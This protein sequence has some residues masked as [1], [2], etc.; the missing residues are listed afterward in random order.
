SVVI[1]VA[2]ILA[3]TVL[4]LTI[5][6]NRY[7]KACEKNA[8]LHNELYAAESLIKSWYSARDTSEQPLPYVDNGGSRL[9]FSSECRLEFD[10]NRLFATDTENEN[11]I[12]L[13]LIYIKSVSFTVSDE[14]SAANGLV[15]CTICY[16]KNNKARY[17]EILLFKRSVTTDGSQEND[18]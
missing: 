2:G 11:E 7:F 13:E 17:R 4:S 8:E 5:A 16:E 14:P 18:G 10:E 12:S 9:V 1:A 15:K 6:L 3:L